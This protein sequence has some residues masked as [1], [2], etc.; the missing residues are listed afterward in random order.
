MPYKISTPKAKEQKN[1][2]VAMGQFATK[3]EAL[4]A[5]KRIEKQ[6]IF[7]MKGMDKVEIIDL[8]KDKEYMRMFGNPKYPFDVQ[9]LTNRPDKFLV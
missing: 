8:R 4:D 5:K 7:F 1:T 6:H 3:K 2:Y 9:I